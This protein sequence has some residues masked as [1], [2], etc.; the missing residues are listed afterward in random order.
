MGEDMENELISLGIDSPVT[1]D[2]AGALYHQQL[3]RQ[4]W[5]L[6]QQRMA[7]KQHTSVS[8]RL[9]GAGYQCSYAH[10]LLRS[11]KWN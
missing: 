1:K 5:A 6:Q 9:T 3:A 7:G 11:E 2:M 10:H 4:V 8:R